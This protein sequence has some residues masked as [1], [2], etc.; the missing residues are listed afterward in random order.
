MVYEG[1]QMCV[2]VYESTV[3]RCVYKGGEIK[4]DFNNHSLICTQLDNEDEI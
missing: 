2:C 1:R 4:L 3:H